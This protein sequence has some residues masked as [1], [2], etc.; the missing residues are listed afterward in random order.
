MYAIA[1]ARLQPPLARAVR[2]KQT[3]LVERIESA[4][5]ILSGGA[6]VRRALMPSNCLDCQIVVGFG[7]NG[8]LGLGFSLLDEPFHVDAVNRGFPLLV[9]LKEDLLTIG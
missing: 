4:T 5:D 2:C 7:Q 3:P 6:G 1:Y 8:R 9:A